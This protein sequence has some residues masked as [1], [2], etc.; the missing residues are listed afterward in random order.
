LRGRIAAAG[1]ALLLLW[2][3]VGMARV[4]P[5]YL[6]YFNEIA[7]GPNSGWQFLAD[8]NTDW[9]Q[10]FGT[11]A[12]YQSESGLGTVKLSAFTFYDP[13]AY[14]VDYDPIAPM[15]GAPTVLR[16]RFN[17]EAGAYAISATTL[18]GVPLAYPATFDWFRHRKPF[19]Q[20]GHVM[21]LYD[22]SPL[23]GTWLAQC[24][25]PVAPLTAEA[26]AEGFGVDGLRSV[27]FDCEQSWVL[28]GD[29]SGT[30]WYARAIE[31]Q[32]RLRWPREDLVRADLLPAWVAS[33]SPV[34]LVVNYV[35]GR[36]GALPAFALWACDA[37]EALAPKA[38]AD[39]QGLLVFQ[40]FVAPA[41]AD[42]GTTIDVLT[43]WRILA[44]PERPV[45]LMLHLRGVD[46]VPIAIGDGLGYPI[47]QWRAGD[48]L[49]Q[50]HRLAIPA[51]VAGDY[52]LHTGAYWL[53]TLV[54][55]RGETPTVALVIE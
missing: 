52:T 37:C 4:A 2:L 17:P 34:G 6:S 27:T 25:T 23:Q 19:A 10:T 3:A 32:T 50:R 31:E 1:L 55:L 9:G 51:G 36:S 35:Q 33:W 39:L 8:S 15:T 43:T 20:I 5:H 28:P 29:A 14:G 26:A 16:R 21:L 12:D 13:A 53:D 22:V 11:L 47:E 46:G 54:P 49:V 48:W 41:S 45:S 7:G 42:N 30:G 38:T 18:D 40:G 44:T 24:S